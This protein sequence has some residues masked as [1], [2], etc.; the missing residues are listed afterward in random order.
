[1]F[2]YLFTSYERLPDWVFG[3]SVVGEGV[4]V[5]LSDLLLFGWVKINRLLFCI[6]VAYP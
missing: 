5:A 2:S 4:F 3:C 6:V 1:M